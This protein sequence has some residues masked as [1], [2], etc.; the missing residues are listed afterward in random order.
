[1]RHPAW[2]LFGAAVCITAG[3]AAF[4][5]VERLPLT[6]GWYWALATAT[7]VGY[8]DV[9]PHDTAGR[10]VAAAVMLTAI[11]LLGAAWAWLAARRVT[12]HMH[13][14]MRQAMRD[15]E[16]A[17]RIAA[18]L[19]HHTTGQHHPAAPPPPRR[20]DTHDPHL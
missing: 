18:D 9:A 7:T 20:G 2:P 1:M 14:H 3:G 6:T 12:M 17:R 4:A 11:P 13:P 5:A 8:G 16:A 19:Y 10:A 15:A